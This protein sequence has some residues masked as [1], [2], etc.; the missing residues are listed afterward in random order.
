MARLANNGFRGFRAVA[1]RKQGR[2]LH[3][4]ARVCRV[5]AGCAEVDSPDRGGTWIRRLSPLTT[6]TKPRT[7]AQNHPPD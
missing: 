1:Y 7:T 6:T 3:L 4:L 2:L 5:A